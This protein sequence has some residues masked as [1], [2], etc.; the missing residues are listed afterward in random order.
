MGNLGSTVTYSSGRGRPGHPVHGGSLA[1]GDAKGRC[2]KLCGLAPAVR[3]L[4]LSAQGSMR[5]GS[6]GTRGLCEKA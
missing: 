3:E 6:G 4:G 5:E 2:V 1:G